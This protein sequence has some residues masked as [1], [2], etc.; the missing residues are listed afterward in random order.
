M[1]CHGYDSRRFRRN[2]GHCR[3]EVSRAGKAGGTA[4]SV[5]V[6]AVVGL[7]ILAALLVV[8]FWLDRII[9]RV[10]SKLVDRLPP[11]RPGGRYRSQCS[12]EKY[13]SLRKRRI[14][15]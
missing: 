15:R 11:Y 5:I 7:A 10:L 4:L 8:H 9:V 13:A 2:S 3:W 1:I 12:P 14:G 6:A